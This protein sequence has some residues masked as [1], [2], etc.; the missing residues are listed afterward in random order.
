MKCS[1]K[2]LGVKDDNGN[3][4]ERKHASYRCWKV[5]GTGNRSEGPITRTVLRIRHDRFPVVAAKGVCRYTWINMSRR[6]KPQLVVIQ[7]TR[8]VKKTDASLFI[9]RLSRFLD[10]APYYDQLSQ[11]R[12]TERR[13]KDDPQQHA[14]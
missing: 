1:L 10:S 5:Q 7:K 8:P 4:S 11:L 14:A 2:S 12:L 13:N 9:V 3:E 6:E